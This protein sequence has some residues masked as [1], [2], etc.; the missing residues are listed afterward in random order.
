MQNFYTRNGR[1]KFVR[2][3][4]ESEQLVVVNP[5]TF[6]SSIRATI[7]QRRFQNYLTNVET[8][9]RAAYFRYFKVTPLT[10][11]SDYD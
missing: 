3:K 7:D 2:A 6:V 10:T 1:K 5:F 8:H 11:D 4:D 9:V